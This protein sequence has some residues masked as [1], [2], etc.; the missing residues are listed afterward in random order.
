M[1]SLC[2]QF[3]ATAPKEATPGLSKEGEG[4]K[5]AVEEMEDNDVDLEGI[6]SGLSAKGN[7]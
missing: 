4:A 6:L 1:L 3:T 7:T 5:Q 2:H